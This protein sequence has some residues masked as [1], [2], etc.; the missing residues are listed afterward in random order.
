VSTHQ[1]LSWVSLACAS[2][3]AVILFWFLILRP[4]LTGHVKLL[5]LLGI[6][7]FPVTAAMTGNVVGLHETQQREFCGQCHVMQPWVQDAQN[8]SSGSLSALHAR[9]PA[10][11]EANC[12]TC[13]ANYEMYGTIATKINGLHHVWEYYA[14]GGR[15]LTEHAATQQISLYEPFPNRTCMECHSTRTR[16]WLAQDDHRGILTELRQGSVSCVSGGCHGPAHPFA[17]GGRTPSTPASTS[18][19][20][21]EGAR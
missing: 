9:N 5:L 2:L 1:L 19:A 6:G 3:A 18:S 20:A 7:V 12:Y 8:P 10:F 17:T 14:A 21:K 4:Q 16:R 11:G 13:H 15:D